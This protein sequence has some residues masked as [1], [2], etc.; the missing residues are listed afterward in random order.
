MDRPSLLMLK[1]LS[2]NLNALMAKVRIN[3]SE[4]ARAVGV[5][6]TTIKRIRNNENANPTITTLL[7]I[8]QYFSISL[9][10]LIGRETILANSNTCIRLNKIPM[11]SLQDCI[12][13][14]SLQYE[15]VPQ[16]IFTERRVGR[17]AFALLI[18]ST[19][20]EL[21]P[22]G[23]IIIVEPEKNPESG[24]YVVVRNIAHGI[25]SI[26]KYLVE[27]DK[28]YLIPLIGGIK[29][30]VLTNDYIVIGVI[31]QYKVDLKF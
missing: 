24:D 2:E 25:A 8:A 29:V 3:S 28:I 23:G 6:A 1:E 19:D 14:L 18:D 17:K 4:L 13:Y 9:N 5:P 7:P 11:L 12:H 20:L 26:R 15:T 22:K 31:I 27:L 16:Q 21:F 30:S 10:Q